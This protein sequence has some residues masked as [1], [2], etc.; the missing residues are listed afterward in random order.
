MKAREDGS[1]EVPL[2]VHV[3]LANLVLIPGEAHHEAQVSMYVAARDEV[4]RTSP[5]NKHLCPVRIVNSELLVALGRSA[6]CGMRL[7]MREGSQRLAVSAQDELAQVHS[8]IAL[9]VEV[10][11]PAAG[12]PSSDD[13]AREGDR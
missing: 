8:T 1:F 13:A 2:L 6:A 5:V 10:P 9:N 4:G 12:D 11:P 7:Q 3:P